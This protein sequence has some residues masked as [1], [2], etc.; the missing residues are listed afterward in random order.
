MCKVRK[1]KLTECRLILEFIFPHSMCVCYRYK[2]PPNEAYTESTLTVM[3]IQL[4]TG[5]EAYLEDLKQ[6][7]ATPHLSGLISGNLL[8]GTDHQTPV[9]QVLFLWSESC[10]VGEK[11]FSSVMCDESQSQMFDPVVSL[12]AVLLLMLFCSSETQTSRSSPTMSCREAPWSFRWTL[13]VSETVKPCASWQEAQSL[14]TVTRLCSITTST[15][16]FT[17]CFHY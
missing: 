8:F 16:S 3:K 13:W 12:P 17:S 2:P 10:C 4:P 15:V 14:V 7:S 1:R 6:V 5:V 9:H 11:P